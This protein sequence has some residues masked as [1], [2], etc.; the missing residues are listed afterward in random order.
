MR[1]DGTERP[2]QSTV[3][4]GEALVKMQG[5]SDRAGELTGVWDS[6]LHLR[7]ARACPPLAAAVWDAA[8]WMQHPRVI[9]AAPP[10]Q[11]AMVGFG[12]HVGSVTPIPAPEPPA[13]SRAKSPMAI[14]RF[15][16]RSLSRPAPHAVVS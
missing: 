9:A 4:T 7:M 14:A 13:R 16:P 3:G 8:L 15:T 1:G 10:A 11:Q 12:R 5:S 6:Q 2:I